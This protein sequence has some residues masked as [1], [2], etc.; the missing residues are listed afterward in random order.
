MCTHLVR[1][2]CYYVWLDRDCCEGMRVRGT[3]RSHEDDSSPV[4]TTN[5]TLA[6]RE[7]A[8][9]LAKDSA[10]TRST[11][12]NDSQLPPFPFPLPTLISSLRWT[13]VRL[14]LQRLPR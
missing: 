7:R 8:A 6:L 12:P 5:T 14:L 10:T 9:D 13:L 2:H 4:N 3:R 1:L 11:L